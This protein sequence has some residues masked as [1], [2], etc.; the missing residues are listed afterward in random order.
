MKGGADASSAPFV[1]SFWM[2]GAKGK[3]T[4]LTG[5]KQAAEETRLETG[6]GL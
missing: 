4:E 2:V 3:E 5:R 1:F 6:K